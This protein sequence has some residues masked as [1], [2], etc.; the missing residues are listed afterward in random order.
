MIIE[1]SYIIYLVISI[2]MTIW[3]A[4]TLSKNGLV[5]LVDSF[6]GNRELA[7]SIN[8][9]LV[10]GFYL[11]NVGYILLKL[12]SDKTL[13]TIRQAIEFLSSQIGF[14]LLILGIMHF[15]NIFVISSWR[16]RALKMKRIS[17]NSNQN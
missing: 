1:I 4:K 16:N 17:S 6:N 11:L 14:A 8:Q 2:S 3:V 15:G 10:V 7:N 5:F 13:E 12:Q 9:L